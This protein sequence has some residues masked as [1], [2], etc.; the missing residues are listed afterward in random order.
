MRNV[1]HRCLYAALSIASLTFRAEAHDHYAVGIVDSNN[2]H[3]PDAGETLQFVGASGT[4]KTYHLLARPF[5]F[6]PVQRCGGYYM[7]DERPRTLFPT[8]SFS[9]TVLSDGQIEIEAPNHA[10]TGAW[11]WMEIVAVAGP[12][13]A[14]FGFWEEN[15]S[16]SNNAPTVSFATNQPTGGYRFVLSEGFDDA[17][18]DP[19]G[20]IHGRSWTADKPGDYYVSMRL[21]DRSTTRPGG[22]AWHAPSQIYTYHFRAGPSFQPATERIPGT[23]FVLTWPSQMG[24]YTGDASQ[25]GI[26]FDIE[27]ATSLSPANWQTIG[28]VTGTIS[29]T[30]TFTD[31]APPAGNAFYRLKY[32]WAPTGANLPPTVDAQ[33]KQATTQKTKPARRT[34]PGRKA[35]KP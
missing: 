26:S 25:V 9:F 10:H 33:T 4:G 24:Y 15:W 16:Q 28:T 8:D 27:R 30:A 2:N 13:G 32:L 6:R 20:H 22:I 3:L 1:L 5:G 12:T 29:D 14:H 19:Q 18:E 23:G 35:I 7:L 17:G 11:I 31:T 34:K 21:V